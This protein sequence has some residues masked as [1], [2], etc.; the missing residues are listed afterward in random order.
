MSWYVITLYM[1][2]YIHHYD[3]GI[4]A[5]L[6]PIITLLLLLPNDNY[7]YVAKAVQA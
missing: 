4:E 1:I 6:T 5:L 7:I 2:I 3:V